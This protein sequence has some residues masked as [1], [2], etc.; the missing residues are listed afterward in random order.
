MKMYLGNTPLKNLK[1]GTNTDDATLVASDLQVGKTG[2]SRGRKVTGTGKAFSFACYGGCNSNEVIPIPVSEINT[3]NISSASYAIKMSDIM[4]NLRELDFSTAK[5]VA[6]ATIDGTDY[7]ITLKVES[8]TIT[9]ACDKT[10]ILQT[11]F[12]KDEYV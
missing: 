1:V 10:I 12:G 7:P 5:T 8:N 2:Y 4:R 6:V 11:V 3:I 9:I